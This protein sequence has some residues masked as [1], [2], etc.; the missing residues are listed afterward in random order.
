MSTV[1]CGRFA[2]P[3][4]IVAFVGTANAMPV[5]AALQTVPPPTSSSG[6]P[7][8]SDDERAVLRTLRAVTRAQWARDAAAFDALAV[9]EFVDLDPTGAATTKV[10]WLRILRDE[11][12][13]VAVEP[14]PVNAPLVLDQGQSLRVVDATAVS[15]EQ[16]DGVAA[17][18]RVRVV[19]VLVKRAG[20]W[21]L[22][23]TDTQL[24][25]RDKR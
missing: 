17:G 15:V 3:V 4:L 8:L 19:S 11:P 16:R 14:K 2:V 1:V 22:L 23:F 7:G 12:S 13:R 6:P 25:L 18:E 20:S 5:A 9:E 10:D 21:R 24:Q